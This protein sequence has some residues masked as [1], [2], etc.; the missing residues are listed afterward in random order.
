MLP[1]NVLPRRTPVLFIYEY[2]ITIGEEV[3][4]FWARK[5]TGASALFFLNRYVPFTLYVMEFASYASMSDQVC[6]CPLVIR[7]FTKP[8]LI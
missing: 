2:F 1:L 8:L 6:R 3:K 5:W 7:S 4:Y